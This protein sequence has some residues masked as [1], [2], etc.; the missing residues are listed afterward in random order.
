MISGVM[1]ADEVRFSTR[2]NIAGLIVVGAGF[3]DLTGRD[4]VPFNGAI[5]GMSKEE[6]EALSIRLWISVEIHDFID[7]EVKFY[8]FACTCV[9]RSRLGSYEPRYLPGG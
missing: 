3:T 7:T 5:F 4:N 6:I 9:W 1:R 8:F 2:G